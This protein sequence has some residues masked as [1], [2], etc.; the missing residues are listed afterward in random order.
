MSN[1]KIESQIKGLLS[2]INNSF[3]N[4]TLFSKKYRSIEIIDAMVLERCQKYKT[5]IDSIQRKYKMTSIDNNYTKFELVSMAIGCLGNKA[6]SFGTSYRCIHDNACHHQLRKR[7]QELG[8]IG[9]VKN[10]RTSNVIGKCAEVKAANHVLKGEKN[11]YINDLKFS[12][13][14]R[15]RTLQ[16][17]QACPNCQATFNLPK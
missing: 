5:E 1:K 3:G 14:R 17:H 11:L 7:L 16:R 4:A 8:A 10:E 6:S 12:P 15:P 9:S 2:P 13:A